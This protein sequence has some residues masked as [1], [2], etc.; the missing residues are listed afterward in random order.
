MTKRARVGVL[1]IA[2]LGWMA[3]GGDARAQ[4]HEA[5]PRQAEQAEQAERA[6]SS[7]IESGNI[8]CVLR[9]MRDVRGALD[10]VHAT[11]DMNGDGRVSRQEALTTAYVI[12]G[13][14][15]FSADGDGD[16]TVTPDEAQQAR[17]EGLIQH[18]MIRL[19][20][21]NPYGHREPRP[22]RSLM[23]LA[24]MDSDEPV[25]AADMR[26]GLRAGVD[27]FFWRADTSRDGT[28]TREEGRAAFTELL[29]A[30]GRSAF[31]RIDRN[32]DGVLSREEVE[33]DVVMSARLGFVLADQNGDAMLFRQEAAFAVKLFTETAGGCVP[34]R[35]PVEAVAIGGRAAV[36]GGLSGPGRP[37]AGGTG[38]AGQAIPETRRSKKSPE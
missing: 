15:F 34:P 12:A 14:F 18:P 26:E 35:A 5:L 1:S 21:L 4:R 17:R 38:P 20:L 7:A 13:G 10:S 24:G 29:R 37:R 27:A 6:R 2:W 8:L 22:W 25:R 23:Q 19:M 30:A 31:E 3:A 16:W 11:A 36:G 33:D 9:A 32:E 28:I